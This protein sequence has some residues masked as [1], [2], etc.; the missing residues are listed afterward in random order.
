[1]ITKMFL[2]WIIIVKIYDKLERCY[3]GVEHELDKSYKWTLLQNTDDGSGINIEDDYQ[4]TVC[5]SKLVVAR[6]LMEDC[7]EEIIDR[8]TKIDVVKSLVYNCG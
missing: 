4:R 7:F 8:H 1:M 2:N 5:H 3:L 6:R